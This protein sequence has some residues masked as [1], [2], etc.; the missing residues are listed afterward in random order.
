MGVTYTPL[1]FKSPHELIAR[2]SASACGKEERFIPACSQLPHQ[3]SR[4]TQPNACFGC[5]QHFTF[6]P[7]DSVMKKSSVPFP[8]TETATSII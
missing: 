4:D 3:P 2:A 5:D 7:N 8:F 6:E 1:M